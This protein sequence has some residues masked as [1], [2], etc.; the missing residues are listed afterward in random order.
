MKSFIALWLLIHVLA[1]TVFS[2]TGDT[3]HVQQFN[4]ENGLPSNG[5]K[6]LQWDEQTGF[7][8]IGTEAGVVR[9]N[10]MEF[11]AFG[12]DDDPHITNERISFVIRNNEGKIFTA[13]N[14]GN[15]FYVKKNKLAF[16]ENRQLFNNPKD[17]SVSLPV[18]DILYKTRIN[19]SGPVA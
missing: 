13:D 3:Y 12:K 1:C 14:L 9:Y 7:L 8:W 16:I 6:G 4:T 19:F 5:I 15:F 17:N 10:G 18:S 11:K 2:Q